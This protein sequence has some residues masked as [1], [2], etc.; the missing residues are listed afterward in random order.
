MIL[1]A[2]SIGLLVLIIV[3]VRNKKLREEYS[4]LW[5][6][7]GLAGPLIA[8]W[9]RPL[10]YLSNILGIFAP[11]NMLFLFAIIFLVI[12]SLYFS[13]KVSS[14]TNHVKTLMQEIVLLEDKMK[15]LM[16]TKPLSK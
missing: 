12:L 8:F 10:Q 5:I 4:F 6:L 16:D 13:V 2:V 11:S 1:L 3:L 7:L 14:L 15:R 9:N